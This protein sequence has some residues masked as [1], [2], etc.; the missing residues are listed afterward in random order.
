MSH[1]GN[2]LSS[3]PMNTLQDIPKPNADAKQIT[4][5]VKEHGRVTGYRLSDGQTLGKEEAVRLAREGGIRGVGISSRKGNEYLKSL[6]DESENN[7]LG[8][9]PSVT[10]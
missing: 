3:L 5:L 9:L 10:Q 7:N 6:P 4:A 8:N 1:D 2:N